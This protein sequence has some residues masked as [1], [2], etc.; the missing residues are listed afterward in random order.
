MFFSSV[1]QMCP[2][3]ADLYAHAGQAQAY[4]LNN[5]AAFPESTR[6][7]VVWQFVTLEVTL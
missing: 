6:L 1:P 2:G 7:A 5:G 3:A 4:K